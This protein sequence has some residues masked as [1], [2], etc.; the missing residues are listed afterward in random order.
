MGLIQDMYYDN[1]DLWGV[2]LTAT[3]MER[4]NSKTNSKYY[5]AEFSYKSI[6]PKKS[7][8]M[9]KKVAN[10]PIWRIDTFSGDAETEIAINYHPPVEE[11]RVALKAA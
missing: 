4:T 3:P 9:L 1:V 7:E 10:I 11:E 5:I 8:E 6:A 2:E